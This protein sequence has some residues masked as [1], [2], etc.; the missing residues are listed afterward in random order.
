[1]LKSKLYWK[2]GDVFGLKKNSQKQMSKID[3]QNGEN[4]Y[5]KNLKLL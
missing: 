1:M 5:F 3:F 4:S 2:V